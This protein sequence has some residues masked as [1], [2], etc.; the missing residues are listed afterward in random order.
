M[1]AEEIHGVHD[2]TAPAFQP[3]YS[4]LS[5]QGACFS[6]AWIQR[7]VCAASVHRA[8]CRCARFGC[9]T[10]TENPVPG[11]TDDDV[12]AWYVFHAFIRAAGKTGGSAV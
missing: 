9:E 10:G 12:S 4:G 6:R 7:G 3:A 2:K 5:I 1:A 11:M 8:G